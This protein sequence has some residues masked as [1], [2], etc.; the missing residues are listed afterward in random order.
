MSEAKQI[1]HEGTNEIVCPY[2]GY[3]FSDSW[4]YS[5]DDDVVECLNDDCGKQFKYYRENL[6]CAYSTSKIEEKQ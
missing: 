4:D 3:K 1:E 2:C 6:G 5:S